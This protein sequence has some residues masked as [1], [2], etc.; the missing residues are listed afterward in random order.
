MAWICGACM[1]CVHSGAGVR[2][3]VDVKRERP[4]NLW[5]VP[6]L[7]TVGA[8]LKAWGQL[9]PPDLANWIRAN[10]YWAEAPWQIDHKTVGDDALAANHGCV[11][12]YAALS[13]NTS[14]TLPVGIM[15]D[16]TM[17]AKAA[18]R[19]ELYDWTGMKFD[20]RSMSAGESLTLA[21]GHASVGVKAVRT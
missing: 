13:G 17:T 20:E 3:V 12:A 4:A 5:D 15:Q 19:V 9:L 21:G 14:W 16:F 1:T 8:A 11:R 2:G 6:S 18:Q 10:D 7:A